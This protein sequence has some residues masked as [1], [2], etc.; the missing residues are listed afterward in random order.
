MGS[1]SAES[2]EIMIHGSRRG[3]AQCCQVS[4]SFPVFSERKMRQNIKNMHFYI[5]YNVSELKCK[6]IV[7]QIK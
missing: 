2:I 3:D 6:K 1:S 5:L 7:L 4:A